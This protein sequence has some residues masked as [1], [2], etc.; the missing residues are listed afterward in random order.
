M[1][2]GHFILLLEGSLSGDCDMEKNGK[3][4]CIYA[5]GSQEYQ[6]VCTR[7]DIA[8]TD[9]GSLKA[10]LLHMKALSTTKAEYMTFTE[11]WKKEIW[12]KGLLTESRYE[13]RLVAGI[14][15]C[16][17]VKGGSQYVVSTQVE[18][19]TYRY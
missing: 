3:W 6:M 10:N 11:A 15:T 2:E 18:I 1:L 7:H 4:S 17:L 5:I 16:A 19:T 14:A 13:L 8:S 12:L 9:V